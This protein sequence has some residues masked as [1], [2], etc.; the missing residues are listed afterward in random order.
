MRRSVDRNG[1]TDLAASLLHW[2][3]NISDVDLFWTCISDR[4][5]RSALSSP[6]GPLLESACACRRIAS[7]WLAARDTD[8]RRD[9]PSCTPGA[10]RG[11]E[12]C[13]DTTSGMSMNILTLASGLSDHDLLARLGI[14]A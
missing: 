5:I 11:R 8:G 1:T 12:I 2:A 6:S 13:S 3:R 14:L 7:A 4:E 9:L 10:Y